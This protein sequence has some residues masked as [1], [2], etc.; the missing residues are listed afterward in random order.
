MPEHFLESLRQKIKP[1]H[2]YTF[3][4]TLLIGFL[5]HAYMFLNRFPNHDSLHNIYS[6]Q[7]KVSS[8]RFFLGPA[9]GLSSYFDL[10]WVIGLFSL[11]FLALTA[12]CVVEWF[13]IKHRTTMLLIGGIIVVFPSVTSTFAY[14]YTA[15]GY[16]L[17]TLFVIFGLYLVS[18][19][20]FGWVI[21]SILIM[22]SIGVYQANIAVAMS[23]ITIY[24]VFQIFIKGIDWK[25]LLFLIGRYAMTLVLGMLGYLGAFKLYTSVFGVTITDYQGLNDVGSVGLAHIPTIL[26]HIRHDLKVFFF[27]NR[28]IGDGSFNLF[29][30]LNIIMLLL[31]IVALVIWFIKNKLYVKPVQLIAAALMFLVYPISLYVV[32][33]TS[34]QVEYHMLMVFSI[35]SVYILVAVFYDNAIKVRIPVIRGAY[36]WIALS[37]LGATVFNFALIANIAYF[38]MELRTEKTLAV[39]NRIVDRIEQLEEFDDITTLA[40]HGRVQ[41]KSGLSSG[42]IPNKIPKMIGMMGESLLAYPAHYASLMENYLGFPLKQADADYYEWLQQQEWFKEMPIW[43]HQDSLYVDGETVVIKFQ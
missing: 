30:W 25:T 40:V 22:L 9:S 37:V 33:F 23:Y 17:G 13:E 21:A 8:G 28:Y 3:F 34:L 27:S 41:L 35:S 15:D 14:M 11:F 7:A 29:E 32:Y 4:G 18:R 19:F 24:L 6:T 31:L 26:D 43:P 16:M 1:S 39:G 10:P 5:A 42:T 20:R 36:S 38:N 12:V 2:R